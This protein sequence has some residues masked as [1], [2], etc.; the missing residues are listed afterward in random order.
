V[1]M[2]SILNEFIGGIVD[3]SK[4]VEVQSEILR[5][6]QNYQAVQLRLFKD[7]P[8]VLST[9]EMLVSIDD[10][11]TQINYDTINA[12]IKLRNGSGNTASI[13]LATAV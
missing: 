11:Q 1:N 10:I 9:S 7:N 5:V 8:S 13:Q 6:L 3:G 2:G 4:R 12:V